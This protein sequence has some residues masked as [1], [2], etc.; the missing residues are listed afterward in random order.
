[1]SQLEYITSAY[2]FSSSSFWCGT[3]S[4][5]SAQRTAGCGKEKQEKCPENVQI[6]CRFW[7]LHTSTCC[8]PYYDIHAH[9]YCWN[10]S[11][12]TGWLGTASIRRINKLSTLCYQV[13]IHL[14]ISPMC[15]VYEGVAQPNSKWPYFQAR[16]RH[17]LGSFAHSGTD[18]DCSKPRNRFDPKQSAPTCSLSPAIYADFYKSCEKI[19]YLA[20]IV[21]LNLPF[22]RFP[23]T[24]FISP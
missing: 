13:A 21:A 4:M 14:L 7:H 11:L 24:C 22:F 10:F 23:K 18:T 19:R 20:I 17:W 3:L 5:E 6:S 15:T 2:S 16:K 12:F 8:W 9:P 1:M